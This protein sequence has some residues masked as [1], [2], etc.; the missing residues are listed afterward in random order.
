MHAVDS[1]CMGSHYYGMLGDKT[2]MSVIPHHFSPVEKMKPKVKV[3][4]EWKKIQVKV[5]PGWETESKGFTWPFCCPT[6]A[7]SW[8]CCRYALILSTS[9][10][11]KNLP[12]ISLAILQTNLSNLVHQIHL[13]RNTELHVQELYSC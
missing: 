12:D 8:A 2:S 10:S 6:S 9:A 1:H 7:M 11:Q 3:S 13:I 4:T 5:S